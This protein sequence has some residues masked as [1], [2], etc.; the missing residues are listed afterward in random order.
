MIVERGQVT[1]I[2]DDCLW[3]AT[4][5]RSSC[6]GCK[7]QAGCGQSLLARLGEHNPQLRVLL[8]GRRAEDFQVGDQVEIGVPESVVA[9]G[10]LIAYFTPLLLLLLFAGLAHYT[11]GSEAFTA[12]AA[13][14]GLLAGGWVL[15]SLSRH[16]RNDPRLQPVVLGVAAA[17]LVMPSSSGYPA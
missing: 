1:A 11:T 4:I 14:V 9:S 13:L 3:V 10:S 12:G 8:D 2:G 7:A 17:P 15:R 16:S 6:S 5:A